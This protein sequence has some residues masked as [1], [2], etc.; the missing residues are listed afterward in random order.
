MV[1]VSILQECRKYTFCTDCTSVSK[2]CPL[3]QAEIV[4]LVSSGNKSASDAARLFRV[5][6]STVVRLLA[7][8]K[9]ASL[10]EAF[11]SAS[12]QEAL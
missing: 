5:H 3:G 7:K 2:T 4:S 8:K 12:Q 11:L 10:N 9:R 1:F 6:P